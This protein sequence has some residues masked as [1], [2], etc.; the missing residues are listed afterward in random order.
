M[1]THPRVGYQCKQMLAVPP[2]LPDGDALWTGLWIGNRQRE[3]SWRHDGV[4]RLTL[5]PALKK[6]GVVNILGVVRAAWGQS[7]QVC[8]WPRS[9]ASAKKIHTHHFPVERMTTEMALLARRCR[10]RLVHTWSV[11]ASDLEMDKGRTSC[12]EYLIET[13]S[14]IFNGGIRWGKR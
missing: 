4:C 2:S 6:K 8:W 13:Y 7:P 1:T 9:A 10:S 14:N 3:V 12:V 11:T 5:L